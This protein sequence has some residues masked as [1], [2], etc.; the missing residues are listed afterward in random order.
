MDV[1]TQKPPVCLFFGIVQFR[2]DFMSR[3]VSEEVLDVLLQQTRLLEWF[4]EVH[5]LITHRD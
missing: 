3:D 1:G 4:S 2:S 5:R